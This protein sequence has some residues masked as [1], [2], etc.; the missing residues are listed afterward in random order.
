MWHFRSIRWPERHTVQ[1]MEKA[2]RQEAS[3][4]GALRAT[5][6]GSSHG[7][8]R[9]RRLPGCVD[10]EDG[11]KKSAE[12]QRELCGSDGCCWTL[13]TLRTRLNRKKIACNL[14]SALLTGLSERHSNHIATM[15]PRTEPSI[16]MIAT[17]P[18]NHGGQCCSNPLTSPYKS[19]S[20]SDS[21]RIGSCSS[22]NRAPTPSRSTTRPQSVVFR[23]AVRSRD[24]SLE[25]FD[26]LCA[27]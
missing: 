5:I 6:G 8:T 2:D 26:S 11:W 18:V 24:S 21:W 16:P 1:A 10:R 27:S 20:S 23:P 19:S 12:S 3:S 7:A 9:R 25:L 13:T 22:S 4:N 17:L 14:L 15:T